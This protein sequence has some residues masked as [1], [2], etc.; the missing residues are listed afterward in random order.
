MSLSGI[1]QAL[2]D[3][4]VTFDFIGF[5][6]CLMATLENAL[7]LDEFGDYLIASEETEPGIGWYYTTW[8]NELSKNPSMPTLQIGKNIV[9]GFVEA[10]NRKCA[11]QK[12][13]LSVVD[14]AELSATV[15]APFKAFS[16]GIS[17]MISDKEYKTVANARSQAR[18]FASSTK[19]DQ[20]DVVHFASNL[21]TAEGKALADAIRGAVKY[22]RTSSNMTNAYGL[23]IFFPLR[24][25]KYVD[26]MSKTYG[27]IKMDTDY[28]KAIRQFASLEVSGQ[29]G[30]GGT[31]SPLGTLFGNYAG[32]SPECPPM[33]VR[34]LW[35]SSSP[36][37]W[38]GT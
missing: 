35:D 2:R 26:S 15:P 18:E 21:G 12:T 17:Q 20:V 38:A 31:G 6:A 7:M 29:A 36:L 25:A 14:L 27:E 4:G 11:G 5:D 10:C 16:K 30:S 28:T 32:T 19:I 33:T 3:G 13:T 9:D 22:N 34:S 37:S 1:S 8:L 24:S 23:S